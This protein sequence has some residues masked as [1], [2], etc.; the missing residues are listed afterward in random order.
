MIFNEVSIDAFLNELAV[1]GSGPNTIRAYRSDLRQ[2]TEFCVAKAALDFEV[3]A[4]EWLTSG[5]TTAAPRTIQRRLA[6]LRS[7]ARWAGEPTFLSRY[8]P[9]SAGRAEPHPLPGG[10]GDTFAM[11]SYAQSP[12]ERALMALCGLAGLRVGEACGQRCSGLDT[13]D[14]TLTVWGKGDKQRVIP[15]RDDAYDILSTLRTCSGPNNTPRRWVSVTPRQAH[16]IIFHLGCQA[17]VSRAVSTH[18]L[19]ATLATA[20]YGASKDLR[21]VQEYLGH[22]SSV[23]TQVYTGISMSDMRS[24]VAAA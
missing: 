21:A 9:P 16:R 15:L 7:Y 19:R 6:T 12:D 1:L 8:R 17:R 18:D 22:S 2:F 11:L 4:A 3:G 5:R 24:A 23:T 13:L 14:R 20:M 10:M